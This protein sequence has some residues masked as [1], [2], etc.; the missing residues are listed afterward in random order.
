MNVNSPMRR[1]TKPGR[2]A[3]VAGVAT[4]LM[5]AAL[6]VPAAT[7]GATTLNTK[8][9]VTSSTGT[10]PAVTG[11]AVTFT[12][13]V[14]PLTASGR[15]ATNAP[16][17][18]GTL[19][20]TVTGS[21]SPSDTPACDSG[22]NVTL[23]GGQ[24]T[25]TFG[26]GLLATGSTYQ[27]TATYTDNVDS[28]D[29][30]SAGAL[31]QTVNPGK[32]TTGV[33][34][35]GS[36][37]SAFQPV[38][39]TATVSIVSPATGTLSGNV[40]FSG[41]TCDGGNS[42]P[43]SGGLAQ[44]IISAGLPATGSPYSVTA[45]YGP[46][47]EFANSTSAVVHQ[48]VTQ[49]ADTITL[50]SSPNTCNGDICTTSQGTPL[51]FTATV[52]SGA[53]TPVGPVNFV[54]IPAGKK[55]KDGLTCDG[56]N[57]VALSGGQATCTFANGLPATVYYTVTATLADPNYQTASATLYENTSLLATDTSVS[58]QKDVT[59]GET[60]AVT[61][62]VTPLT[63]SSNPPTGGVDITVC[64][65]NSNGGN[66]CQGAIEP[67]ADGTAVLEV[68]GGEFPGKYAAYA[69]YVGDQNYLGSSAKKH[70]F[71]VAEAPTTIAIQSS[72][73]PSID[74]DPVTLTAT[75]TAANGGADSTLV[76]PPTGN[77]NFTITGP[78]GT[79]T[80]QDGNSVPLDNG[81]A[82]EDV[83]QCFLPAGTLTDP[84]APTG[85][86]NY[87]VRVDYASDGDYLSSHST[88]T[89]EVVPAID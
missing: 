47:P 13:T 6:T 12:A 49:G 11:Q 68:G 52:T 62:T 39:F 30:G 59:A 65:G 14:E 36:P 50:A 9:V 7:A 37:S 31:T 19:V 10:H 35:S 53:G 3:L 78:S 25:C 17:P 72:E 38:T 86:T 46:D 27:V 73:N 66:G 51:T 79:Y 75:I 44:C 77:L 61:A 29:N 84:A 15:I 43:V 58:V 41:V 81:Q 21:D 20:F 60:F 57:S 40:T 88:I 55:A 1:L 45:T 87:T 48:V 76:G 16:T 33:T 32:T 85:N 18:Q 22:D 89:Q 56:G 28:N 69:T 8:T 74:G 64:G 83:A 71:S 24:A 42:V 82:D 26:A 63:S 4:L 80:C 54:I 5:G 23:S 70:P 67:V 2:M 34:S